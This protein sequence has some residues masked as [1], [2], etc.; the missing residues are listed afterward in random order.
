[1]ICDSDD[2]HHD[3]IDGIWIRYVFEKMGGAEEQLVHLISKV[4]PNGFGEMVDRSQHDP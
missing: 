4:G 2:L 3:G 1:M